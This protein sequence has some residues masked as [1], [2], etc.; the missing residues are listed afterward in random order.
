MPLTCLLQCV[1]DP[2]AF[3]ALICLGSNCGPGV[4]F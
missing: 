4:C 1:N 3:Q 2:E